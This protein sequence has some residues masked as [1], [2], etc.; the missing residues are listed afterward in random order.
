MELLDIAWE[1]SRLYI[2]VNDKEEAAKQFGMALTLEK[3]TSLQ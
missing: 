3:K 2:P 1:S